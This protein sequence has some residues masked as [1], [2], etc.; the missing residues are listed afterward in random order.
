M[1]EV[2]AKLGRGE[3]V[4]WLRVK[5]HDL[6]VPA[7]AR[8][9]AA[10]A[11]FAIAQTHHHAIVLLSEFQLFASAFSL[12]RSCFEA[13]V[14]GQW[15]LNCASDAQLDAFLAGGDPPAFGALISTLENVP[16]FEDKV[17]SGIK[18]Q[19]W[20]SLCAYTHSGSLHLQRW[21]SE[22]AVEPSYSAEEI[23]ERCPPN[24]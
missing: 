15:L 18:T 8:N 1:A 7:N 16:G 10:L 4:E 14:R 24:R 12:L 22:A 2:P 13:Y 19:H 6:D 11:A 17:L 3:Y 21:Q 9:R 5:V 20:R 23:E